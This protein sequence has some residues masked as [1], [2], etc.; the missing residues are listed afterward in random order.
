[1]RP[2]ENRPLRGLYAVT[3]DEADTQALLAR[4]EPALA[5]GVVLVQYRNKPASAALRRQQA[6]ALLGLCQTYGAALIINDDVDLA[7]ELAAHGVHVGREDCPAGGLTALR[8]R[9]G[10]QRLLGVSCYNDF[11]RAEEA[12]AAGADYVAFGALFPSST[13]PLAQRASLDLL[14]RAKAHL[15]CAVAGIG[16]ITADNGPLAI[17]AGADLLAVISD[18]FDAPDIQARARAYAKAFETN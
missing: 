3:P 5:G 2:E 6:G 7:L 18:L 4:L 14:G 8:Q 17:Q 11:N 16:G 10:P 1:M 12:A 15:R 13:K 9:L